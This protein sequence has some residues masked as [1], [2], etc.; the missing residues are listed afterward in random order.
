MFVRYQEEKKGNRLYLL[1]VG[2]VDLALTG[3]LDLGAAAGARVGSAHATGAGVT[4]ERGVLGSGAG[5]VALAGG[6]GATGAAGLSGAD[7]AAGRLVAAG[8]RDHC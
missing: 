5:A 1:H 4:G 7:A 3:I 2:K 6:V 8:R